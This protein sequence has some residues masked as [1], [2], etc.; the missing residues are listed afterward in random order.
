MNVL[1]VEPGYLPYEKEINGLEEM[2][3]VVG[4]WIE[5]IYPY[6]EEVAIVCNEEG[7][8]NGLQRPWRLRRCVR[9]VLYLRP[10]RGR[11]LFPPG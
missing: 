10:G 3:A 8:I 1:V 5:A 7:L 2:Q 6:E 4:S 9:H 11:F